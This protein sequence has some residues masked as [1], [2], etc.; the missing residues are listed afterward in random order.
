MSEQRVRRLEQELWPRGGSRDVYMIADAARDPRVFPFLLRSHLEY[1]CLY[2]GRVSPKLEMV[3]PYLVQL[4]FDYGDTRELLL[5][6][7]GNSWGVFLKTGASMR[8]LRDHLR[9]FL[10]VRD[11]GGNRLVFRYYDPRVLRVYL[12]ACS[13]TELDTIFGPVQRFWA[14]SG[15]GSEVIEFDY[16]GE[17]MLT[18]RI[19]VDRSASFRERPP[20]DMERTE[21]VRSLPLVMRREQIEMFARE[22]RRKFEDWMVG[23]LARC[24]PDELRTEEARRE[25]ARFGIRKALI[26][27]IDRRNDVCRFV[28]LTVAVGPEFEH[29]PRFPWALGMLEREVDGTSKISAVHDY[30]R[31]RLMES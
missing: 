20:E 9:G 8:R 31:V 29:D 3:A 27:G 23:H 16:G 12:P 1:T 2:S 15:D 24:F 19:R 6:A 17:R 18:A 25:A 7:W 4:D 10:M 28:D 11:P 30:I 26:F 22:E 21:R 14:E 5:N 13:A